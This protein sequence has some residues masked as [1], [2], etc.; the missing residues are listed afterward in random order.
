MASP[1]F[2]GMPRSL[3]ALVALISL[4]N[5]FILQAMT[6]QSILEILKY[7]LPSIVVLIACNM[8]V[9]RFLHSE[10][11]GKKIAMLR[12]NQDVTVRLRLQA[13]ERLILFIERVHPRQ[14][15]PRVYQPGMTVSDLQAVLVF[16]IK[17]EFEHNLSQ[18][19]YVSKQIWNAVRGVKEQEINM[20]NNIAQQL[21]AEAP[22]KELHKR[23]VDYVMTVD[24]EIPSDVALDLLNE[25]AKEVLTYGASKG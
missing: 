11:R 24:G 6:T 18:Q 2:S 17:S 25:E 14:L 8:I 21:E 19:L 3:L 23:I 9:R 13:Y 1:R 20:I 10:V 5:R 4:Q 15:V 7:I 12:D 22:A 16:T